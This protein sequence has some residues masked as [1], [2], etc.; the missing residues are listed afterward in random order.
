MAAQKGYHVKLTG[1]GM[2]IDREV[3]AEVAHRIVAFVMGVEG[4]ELGA[5]APLFPKP[6]E[7]GTQSGGTG[8]KPP[9]SVREYFSQH[10]AKKIPQQIA[11]I[12][13]YLKAHSGKVAFTKKDLVQGFEDAQEP[14]PK[15]LPRDI[16]LTVSKG[17]IA[18]K[19]GQKNTYYV[20]GT[21]EDSVRNKFKSDSGKVR[22]RRVR[23]KKQESKG[24][25]S[26]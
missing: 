13:M 25:S 9:V 11:T 14:G 20:T 8:E 24:T 16:S 22:R 6:G 1:Q 21:G 19:V 18:P 4:S 3:S 17:W 2:R 12:G 5:A 7:T 15:N 26:K 10:E 23:K